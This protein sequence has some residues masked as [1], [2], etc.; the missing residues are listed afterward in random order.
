M[1]ALQATGDT[2][3]LVEFTDIP[4][5]VPAAHEALIRVEAF[6]LNRPDYLYLA[7]PGTAYRPGID[8]VGVVECPAADGSGPRAGQRVVMHVP[9][10]GAAAERITV[11]AARLAAVPG[12]LASEVAACL[13]LAGMVA[14][15]LLRA[16]G[17][18]K[19]LNLLATGA[20]G[21][22]GQFLVQL[23]VHEGAAIT[24]VAREHDPWAHLARAGATV[25]HDVD[26]LP[27]GGFDVVLESVGGRLGSEAALRLRTGGLF[28][29][30]GQASAE[31]LTLDFFELFQGG[32]SMTLRHFV[33]SGLADDRE[34]L[35]LL[36][37]LAARGVLQV[38]IGHRGDWGQT[39]DVL[40]SISRGELR[41]KAVLEVK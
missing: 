31:P 39:A 2:A 6:S 40:D 25:V 34:D 7:M 1:R 21:G 29:W 3:R 8:A 12:T 28:L 27:P 14:L 20:T 26:H 19:G 35:D 9:S 17:P 11:P 10:G 23:A 37:D 32:Q 30:Y 22:V 41:G 16:A 4:E 5:P 24:V 15:R 18:L 36:L 33:Y 38:E 13:P